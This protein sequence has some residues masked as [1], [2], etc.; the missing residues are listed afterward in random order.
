MPHYLATNS[1][2]Q[3][4][5]FIKTYCWKEDFCY[6]FIWCCCHYY[7]CQ[8]YDINKRLLVYLRGSDSSPNWLKGDKKTMQVAWD[9]LINCGLF[10][11]FFFFFLVV[12]FTAGISLDLF[13]KENKW[14]NDRTLHSLTAK[15]LWKQLQIQSCP[16]GCPRS[17]QPGCREVL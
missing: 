15:M 11:S 6:N 16:W 2:N 1:R 12:G 5:Q 3:Y 10:F 13:G 8:H 7:T 14:N 4:V 17:N 9:C